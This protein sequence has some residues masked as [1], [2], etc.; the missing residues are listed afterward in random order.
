VTQEEVV[1]QVVAA[2][3]AI[4]A[5]YMIT[6]SFASNLHGVPRMTQHADIVVDLDEAAALRLVTL[7]EGDFY[8]SDEAARE[9]A[10]LRRMFNAIHLATG[11]KVDLIVCKARA[12]SAEE[13]RRRQPSTLAGRELHFA[14]PED[15]LLT[16]LEWALLGSSERQYGDALGILQVQSG[17][18]DW[19]YLERWADDLGVRDLLERARHGRGFRD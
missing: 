14:T 17:R 6:G 5:N 2:I 4:G 8:V 11:F 13:L 9:A 1:A 18:L 3:D 12:F 16:K 7:L 19:E 15:T 10:R